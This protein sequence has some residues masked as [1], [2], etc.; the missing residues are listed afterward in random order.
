MM[1]LTEFVSLL[2]TF[3]KMENKE[4]KDLSVTIAICALN[5]EANIGKLLESI[6]IQREEDYKLERIWVI[7]DGSTD[8]TVEIAKSFGKKVEVTDYK[9]RIGKSSRL[10]EIY[11]GVTSEI[12][13]QPDADVILAN[14][15][16]IRD[17]LLPFQEGKKIGMTGGNTI[18]LPAE[19]FL[20]KAVNCTL[21]VYVPFRKTLKG[22]NNILSATGRL[23][24]LRKEVYRNIKVPK[25]TIAN[26]GFV[27]F[28][29]ITQ[30]Y[31]YRYAKTADVYFRSPQTLKDHISQNTRFSA[32]HTWM[33][34]FFPPELVEDEYHVPTIPFY[35]GMFKQ[36]VKHPILSGYIFIINKYCALRA[37]I[38]RKKINAIWDIVY[39]TKR[40]KND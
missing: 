40:L 17:L 7:S 8:K 16:V 19:T 31:L 32:T 38:L 4:V 33:K 11:T 30:G 23:L 25:D 5:E 35:I 13:V 34:Q 9:E 12:V 26:D 15:Y 24:A 28:C 22:G 39:S 36:F 21:E 14:P 2:K 20:E 18:P 6:M 29:T 37:V 10:N 3:M 27:Y 1:K